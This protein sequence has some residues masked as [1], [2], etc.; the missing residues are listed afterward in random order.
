MALD[1]VVRWKDQKPT[2][3]Q[4][5][6]LLEDFFGGAAAIV[7]SEDLRRWICTLPGSSS[8]P[9]RRLR[10]DVV[11]RGSQAGMQSSRIIE[12]VPQDDNVDVITRF[13]DRFTNAL[14]EELA[15]LLAWGWQGER[16]PM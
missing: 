8:E 13:V 2:N 4:I 1:R 7:W 9:F 3:D 14:T 15:V 12:V 11:T 6:I 16:E 10:D 5:L